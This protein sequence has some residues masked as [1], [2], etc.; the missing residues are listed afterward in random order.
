[1]LAGFTRT[2]RRRA[3]WL[4][5]LVYLFCV[6]APTISFALPGGHTT[7]S[8]LIDANHVA[9]LVHEHN[10]TVAHVHEGGHVHDHSGVQSHAHA[11][12]DHQAKPVALND[13][14]NPVKAPHSSDGKCCSL[15]CITALPATLV[16]VAKPLAPK[17]IRETESHR[18]LTDNTPAQRYRPP[19]S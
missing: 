3:G 19:I 5:A 2:Q 17:V 6:L 16:N 14:S 12:G 11:A 1:M 15:M 10:A 4:V 8:C 7:P 13:G 9:G 18:K